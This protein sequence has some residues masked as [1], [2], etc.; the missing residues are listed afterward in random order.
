MIGAARRYP[1]CGSLAAGVAL[2]ALLGTAPACG[3]GAGGGSGSTTSG[4]GGGATT[5]GTGGSGGGA[6]GSGGE[7]GSAQPI[8]LVALQVAVGKAHSCALVA[9]GTVACWG[10]G[11]LGQ[12]GDGLSG[13][14]HQR[15]APATIPGLSGVKALRAGGDTTCALLSDAGKVTCWGAGGYGQLGNGKAMDGYFEASPVPA[16]ELVD[17]VDLSV[18]G[19]NACAVLGNGTV[20]CWGRNDAAAWLGFISLDC[21]PYLDPDGIGDPTPVAV[22]CET[23]PKEVGALFDAT[24]VTIG[25]AHVCALRTGGALSCWGADSFGQLGD[26][27]FGPDNHKPM[28]TPVPDL[29]GV[30]LVRAGASHTCALLADQKIACWG[31]NAHAQLGIGTDALDSYKT[32]PNLVP[33]LASVIALDV[34]GRTSCVVTDDRL[35]HCW[36]EALPL[37]AVPP[38]PTKTSV[39]SPTVIPD[40]AFAIEVRAAQSHACA[41][42]ATNNVV[43]W[44]ENDQGQLGNGTTKASDFSLATVAFF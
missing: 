41:K 39:L 23:A 31:D 35:V 11:D 20:R 3:G 12:L 10:A 29:I 17:V 16:S 30:Q 36:G 43:C 42:K 32:T 24:Q 37:F 15:S 7:G 27:T 33:G 22:P 40:L 14:D 34:S 8:P 28:P 19:P 2:V 26:G 5:S 18:A 13:K 6:G 21:G 4:T 38:D 9:G 44:G 1:L 25:G